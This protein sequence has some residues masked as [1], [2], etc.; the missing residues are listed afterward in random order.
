MQWNVDCAALGEELKMS[1]ND[2]VRRC[3]WCGDPGIQDLIKKFSE[4]IEGSI[5]GHDSFM[6]EWGKVS[7]EARIEFKKFMKT[8]QEVTA[9]LFDEVT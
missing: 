3:V 2:G 1:H 7:E 6:V 5:G 4:V 9:D 8:F